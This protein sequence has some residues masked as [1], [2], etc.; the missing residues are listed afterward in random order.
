MAEH[1]HTLCPSP[2]PTREMLI[3]CLCHACSVNSNWSPILSTS[4]SVFERD[5]SPAIGCPEVLLPSFEIRTHHRSPV[6]FIILNSVFSCWSVCSSTAVKNSITVIEWLL[7]SVLVTSYLVSPLWGGLRWP[8]KC[9]LIR[10]HPYTQISVLQLASLK[11][12]M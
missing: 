12:T 5:N 4:E 1:T 3:Y 10:S 8:P 11:A 7:Q 9:R 6:G 2:G